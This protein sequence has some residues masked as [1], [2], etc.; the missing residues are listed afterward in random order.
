MSELAESLM[1]AA[2][3]D[4]AGDGRGHKPTALELEVS[5][6]FDHLRNPVLRY[7]LSLGLSP[8]D[9]EEVVQEA[10]L[11][12]FRHLQQ[13]KP[14]DNLRGWLFRVA[15]NQALKR[16]GSKPAF[17]ISL[18]DSGAEELHHDP[19]PNPEEALAAKQRRKR[20]LAVVRALPEQDR[21]CLHLRAEGLRYREI[22]EVLGMSLG[23]VSHSLVRSLERL[24]RADGG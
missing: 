2:V 22:A 15:H 24:R 3:L 10:F 21:C 7:V 9:G 12:L 11:S 13:G 20:L 16:R 6:L 1:R 8:Q 18:A 23:A 17:F 19:A 5:A 14:R 4:S